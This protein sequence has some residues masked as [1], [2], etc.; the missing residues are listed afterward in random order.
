[1][2]LLLLKALCIFNFSNKFVTFFH[3]LLLRLE[4]FPVQFRS[5]LICVYVV[6][7]TKNK[8]LSKET[9]RG[10][11]SH[12]QIVLI[13]FFASFIRDVCMC[14]CVHVPAGTFAILSTITLFSFFLHFVVACM[15]LSSTVSH[16][17]FL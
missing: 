13:F 3:L 17:L 10:K 15:Q 9:A 8:N 6:F 7:S 16:Y 11:F 12:L 14:V 1:M 4:T 2:F 5:I